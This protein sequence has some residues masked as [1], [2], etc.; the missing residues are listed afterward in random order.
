MDIH[1]I[2]ISL[3][4]GITYLTLPWILQRAARRY[5]LVAT[6]SPAF[7]CYVLGIVLGN[8]MPPPGQVREIF[9]MITVPPA[10]PL[11]LFSADLR[12]WLRL[13]RPALI[14]QGV[15]ITAVLLMAWVAG[16]IFQGVLP[17]AAQAA[18]MSLGV[19]VGATANMAAIQLAIG[20]TEDLFIRMNINDMVVSALYLAAIFGGAQR[21]LLR[22]LPGFQADPE[23]SQRQTASTWDHAAPGTRVRYVAVAL[24]MALALLGVVAGIVYGLTGHL[25]QS[26]VIVLL[27]AG[28]LALSLVKRIRTWPGTYETGEYLFLMF[29][30]VI[31]SAVSP[32]TLT[33]DNL[34]LIG[35]MAFVAY[36]AILLHTLI[37]V[38][39]RLDADTVI[40][41]Q[42]AAIFSPPFIGPA[43]HA[44][45]NREIVVTGLTMAVVNMA[46]GNLA[47]LL[48]YYWLS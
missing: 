9:Q 17:Y 2:W 15:Y 26:L 27:T 24:A 19:Y 33:M 44:L 31:G 40:I 42:I 25:H 5:R 41:T 1:Q 29:C 35:L 46:L 37:A 48:M 32:Q 45:H 43:A 21:W 4:S 30:I 22:F 12:R 20:A 38:R 7:F 14:S 39:L 10:I 8:L 3:L 18:A 47:G 34:P 13:A 23:A 16:W 6:L 11:L 28:G 36:G